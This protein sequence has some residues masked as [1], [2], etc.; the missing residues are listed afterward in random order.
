MF[1]FTL[2]VPWDW[3]EVSWVRYVCAPVRNGEKGF[4]TLG[5]VLEH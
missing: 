1:T 3:S 4:L 5:Q 2:G